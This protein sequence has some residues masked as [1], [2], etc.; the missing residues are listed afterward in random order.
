MGASLNS[1]IHIQQ[2]KRRRIGHQYTHKPL[3]QPEQKTF[4]ISV[5]DFMGREEFADE[6]GNI[7]PVL[8]NYIIGKSDVLFAG[9]VDLMTNDKED[10]IRRKVVEV[11]ASRIP[12]VLPEDFSFVKVTRKEV[13]TPACKEG[14][15]WDFPQ[16]KTIAG[17]GKLYVRLER[18]HSVI[19]GV[20]SQTLNNPQPSCSSA[21]VTEWE[22]SLLSSSASGCASQSPG[23][24][25]SDPQPSTS[26]VCVSSSSVNEGPPSIS[27][28]GATKGLG[29]SM[30]QNITSTSTLESSSFAGKSDNYGQTMM[31]GVVGVKDNNY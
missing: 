16:V 12:G 11:L 29:S 22:P 6:S 9:T 5:V 23:M 21:D 3:K 28:K 31:G 17:Q 19:A 13:C 7:P 25:A 27:D 20:A 4:E 1:A 2:P 14:H 26:T 10:A 15:K 18:P 24:Y 8:P 30:M